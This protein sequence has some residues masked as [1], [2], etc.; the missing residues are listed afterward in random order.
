MSAQVDCPDLVKVKVGKTATCDVAT[1][2][3]RQTTLTFTW[4]DAAGSVDSSS[5]KTGP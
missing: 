3:G 5:V 4:E 2:G 1:A